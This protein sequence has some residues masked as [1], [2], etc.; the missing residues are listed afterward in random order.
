META[1]TKSNQIEQKANETSGNG[2]S[3]LR[4]RGGWVVATLI[5][6]L[7]GLTGRLNELEPPGY[8]GVYF[9]YG[10]EKKTTTKEIM[11]QK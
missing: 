1:S 5:N 8:G 2:Q 7:L 4:S 3:Y 11:K 6:K 10:F 9:G